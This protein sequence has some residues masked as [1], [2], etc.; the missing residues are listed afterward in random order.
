MLFRLNLKKLLIYP[1]TPSMTDLLLPLV[2]HIM[3]ILLQALLKML[4][5][6]IGL[7]MVVLWKEDSGGIVMVSLLRHKLINS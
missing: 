4:L 6:G 5:L 7:K 1:N 2:F 3:D